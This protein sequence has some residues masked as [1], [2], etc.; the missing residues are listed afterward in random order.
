[1]LM[2][3]HVGLGIGHTYTERQ[4]EAWSF[5]APEDNEP[6]AQPHLDELPDTATD[7]HLD[8]IDYDAQS[9]SDDQSY[10]SAEGIHSDDDDS[11]ESDPSV[12]DDDDYIEEY[13]MYN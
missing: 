5:S 13:N 12:S 10:S 7:E 2:R 6:V 9:S 3:Y 4:S 11:G 1:M 8:P